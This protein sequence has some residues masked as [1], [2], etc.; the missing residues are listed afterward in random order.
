MSRKQTSA[1]LN[2]E[3][4]R[5]AKRQ[6]KLDSRASRKHFPK[7]IVAGELPQRDP[8]LIMSV[9]HKARTR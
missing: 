2:R 4:A 5:A 1:K 9:D 3:R 6:A 7:V 8:G